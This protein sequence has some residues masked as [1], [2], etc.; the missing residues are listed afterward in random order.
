MRRAMSELDQLDAPDI[1]DR[2]NHRTRFSEI[3]DPGPELSP[4]VT[5][6]RR[7]SVIVVAL[8]IFA[9]AIVFTWSAFRPNGGSTLTPGTA[10]ST[11]GSASPLVA[12]LN[13]PEDGSI[14]SLTLAYGDEQH[15]FIAEDGHWPGVSGFDQ[16]GLVFPSALP[17]GTLVQIEGNASSVTGQ[18]EVLDRNHGSTGDVL[19]LDLQAGSA[20]IP[21]YAASYRLHLTGTWPQGTAEFFVMIDVQEPSGATPSYSTSPNRDVI[22]NG[23][24][25]VVGPW[26]VFVDLSGLKATYGVLLPGQQ[27][28]TTEIAP[29][30]N[31]AFGTW[32]ITSGTGDRLL[33][34][35]VVAPRA[36]G[37][38]VQLDDGT[39]VVGRVVEVPNDAIGP[40]GMVVVGFQS[41]MTVEGQQLDPN[42]WLVLIDSNGQEIARRRLAE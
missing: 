41:A 26:S 20:T 13:A 4:Q 29:L 38:E 7:A 22:A 24:D 39:V 31:R 8:A 9:V 19:P 14:P 34:T 6:A 23:T 36:T 33:L 10:A 12:T 30:D 2:V 18:V 35:Q 42:G 32:S 17:P 1:R 27:T 3:P 15:D 25:A 16:P 21:V 28:F 11:T 37:A 5:P 40:A